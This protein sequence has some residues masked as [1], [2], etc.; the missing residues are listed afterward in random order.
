MSSTRKIQR[1]MAR[2]AG[3]RWPSFARAAERARRGVRHRN[4]GGGRWV[5]TP[6]RSLLV[7]KPQGSLLEGLRDGLARMFGPPPAGEICKACGQRMPAGRTIHH[8][9]F[10]C[11]ARAGEL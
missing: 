9:L 3:Q 5:R 4:I 6:Q 1:A 11:P 2:A 10:K 8:R 7:S